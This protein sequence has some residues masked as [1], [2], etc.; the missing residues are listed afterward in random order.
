MPF[1]AFNYRWDILPY[2]WASLIDCTKE[3]VS[4]HPD[5]A[6][7]IVRR[8]RRI[9]GW[10]SLEAAMLF[11]WIDDIQKSNGIAGDIFEIGV[12]HGRSAIMLGFMAQTEQETFGVCDVF[13]D[14]SRNVSKS[15]SGNRAVF[16][17]HMKA[18]FHN[19]LDMRIFSG[20]SSDISAQDI[21]THHRFFHIDGGHDPDEAFNDLQLAAASTISEGVIVV[22]DP[23]R[24]E[25]PGVSEAVLRFLLSRTEF[26]A[27]IMGFNKM[28]LTRR[29]YASHY[30]CEVDRQ[31]QH[32][33]YHILYPWH[34]KVAR[35]VGYP[36]RVFYVPTYL[37]VNSISAQALRLLHTGRWMYIPFVRPLVRFVRSIKMNRTG[38]RVS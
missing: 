34:M 19:R 37:S 15:G 32:R 7:D 8:T 1:L 31:D 17:G 9:D 23:L 12:H 22:D 4:M 38:C 5:K 25:W 29:A 26:C 35:F 13:D 11:A 30:V 16:E 10:F 21:G 3:L 36:M 24:P 20:L 6:L 14:Q 27:I 2:G 28:V 18:F 33:M